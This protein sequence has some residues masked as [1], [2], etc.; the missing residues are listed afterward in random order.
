MREMRTLRKWSNNDAKT[1][2]YDGEKTLIEISR[3]LGINGRDL[4]KHTDD[5]RKA[6]KILLSYLKKI[7]LLAENQLGKLCWLDF[8]LNDS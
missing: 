7:D 4:L 3:Q 5:P 1:K 2:D 8:Q 6:T